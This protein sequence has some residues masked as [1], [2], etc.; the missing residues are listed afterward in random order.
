MM[1]RIRKLGHMAT[2]RGKLVLV[3]LMDGTMFTDRFEDRTRSK[4][5][6]FAERGR[7]HTRDIRRVITSPKIIRAKIG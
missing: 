5:L 1:K 2:H 3:E 6:I 4:M 7:V